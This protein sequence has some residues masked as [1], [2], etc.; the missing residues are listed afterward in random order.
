MVSV[1]NLDKINHTPEA[2]SHNAP[3]KLDGRVVTKQ[4]TKPHVEKKTFFQNVQAPTTSETITK[5]EKPALRTSTQV[6][7]QPEYYGWNTKTI[8]QRIQQEHQAELDQSL[9]IDSSSIDE[10]LNVKTTVEF[11]Q[12]N[13]VNDIIKRGRPAPVKLI[14]IILKYEGLCELICNKILLDDLLGK[15]EGVFFNKKITVDELNKQS[16]IKSH[17]LTVFTFFSKMLAFIFGIYPDN[18]FS[19]K[20][21]WKLVNKNKVNKD[22]LFDGLKKIEVGTTLKLEVFKKTFFSFY[23][24]SLLVKKTNKNEFTFF[25]P[26]TGEHRGLSQEELAL[27]INDQL[28]QWG[29]TDIFIL[30]GDHYIKRLKD[31]NGEIFKEE[32]GQAVR[33]AAHKL[34]LKVVQAL[35]ADGEISKADRGLA[36][37]D[38]SPQH[39]FS[40]PSV[41]LSVVQA[42]L[43][44]GEISKEDRGA[45]L[46]NAASN[47]RLKVVQALVAN[48]PI[49]EYRYTKG[50][51][52]KIAELNGHKSTADF[53]RDN[54]ADD[55]VNE[56]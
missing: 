2:I 3:G 38:A 24:H 30:R 50:N 7:K 22:I 17:L 53:L 13:I 31:I 54:T 51:A 8:Q 1:I 9:K 10:N 11:N 12:I 37:R 21:Q 20:N 46:Y 34:D 47:G 41:Q 25:D 32:R 55:P 52:L 49:T 43:A 6:H 42:L 44:N 36:V 39:I 4:T 56:L 16:I 40:D 5:E 28:A 23:G 33:D 35:L 26:N 48:G 29:G 19:K 45:A 27:K 14:E 15:G 18:I